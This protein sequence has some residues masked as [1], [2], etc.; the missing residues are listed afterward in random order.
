MAVAAPTRKAK[1]TGNPC[2]DEAGRFCTGAGASAASSASPE[3][4]KETAG[5]AYAKEIVELERKETAA[6]ARASKGTAAERAR[7]KAEVDR[8]RD[9]QAKVRERMRALGMS[10]K[11]IANAI[12]QARR[13]KKGRFAMFDQACEAETEVRFLSEI[14]KVDESLGLVI[15]WGLICKENGETYVDTQGDWLGEAAMLEGAL[16]FMENSRVAKEQHQGDQ[17]GT[18]VFAF[19]MTL[20]IAESLG[21]DTGGKS[22]LLVGVRG[23]ADMIAKFRSGE[24]TG[25]SIGGRAIEWKAT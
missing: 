13:V 10:D 1:Q 2:H 6:R 7:A 17:R 11:A 5:A 16:E 3:K 4:E 15:G 22:G 9:S 24:L 19:P 23:D 18:V 25:F 20:D 14:T 8:L 21:F 12:E